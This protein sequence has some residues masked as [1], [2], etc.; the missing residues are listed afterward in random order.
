[1]KCIWEHNGN[2]ALL[3]CADYPGAYTRGQTLD[4]AVSKMP[5]EIQ[6][7]LKW[8]GA[9]DF[10]ADSNV[11]IVQEKCSKLNISDADSDVIFYSEK[12][13]LSMEEYLNLKQLVLKSASDFYNLYMSVPDKTQSC[14]QERKTFY[15]NIPTTAEEMYLHTKNVNNYYFEEINIFCDN[16]GSICECRKRGFDLLEKQNGFLENQIFEGSYGEL[17]SLRKMMRRFIWHDRIHAKAMYRMS[18]KTFGFESIGNYFN[19]II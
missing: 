5:L 6:S 13:P 12:E 14:L 17:W 10:C 16:N 3:Y 8:T 4:E 19:F 9:A 1:M 11:E 15:G 2:D 18:V 7:Y